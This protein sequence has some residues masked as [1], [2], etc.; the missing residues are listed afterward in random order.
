M[1][2]VQ[3]FVFLLIVLVHMP[4]FWRYWKEGQ[5]TQ[6]FFFFLFPTTEEIN[7]FALKNCLGFDQSN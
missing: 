2:V 5:L 7:P 6:S 4:P 1:L 3:F